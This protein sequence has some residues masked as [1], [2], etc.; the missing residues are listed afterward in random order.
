MKI[1]DKLKKIDMFSKFLLL[2][3]IFVIFYIT[4]FFLTDFSKNSPKN[5][6]V[7][8]SSKKSISL[9]DYFFEHYQTNRLANDMKLF[10]KIN[11]KITQEDLK[12]FEFRVIPKQEIQ[13][14]LISESLIEIQFKEKSPTDLKENILFVLENGKQLFRISYKNLTIEDSKADEIFFKR[15]E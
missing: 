5:E 3:I 1:F 9:S 13:A 2:L 6:L 14:S 12:N 10:I 15:T 8:V 4:Y 7:E 11:E